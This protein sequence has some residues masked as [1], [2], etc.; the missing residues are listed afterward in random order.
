MDTRKAREI[1]VAFDDD[2]KAY[3]FKEYSDGLY[4]YDTTSDDN[5]VTSTSND[6]LNQYS[7]LQT[8]QS[9]QSFFSHKDLAMADD[10]RLLQQRLGFPGTSTMISYIRNN[11][12]CNTNVT[13]DDVCRGETVYGP[14]PQLLKGKCVDNGQ[15]YLP[16]PN[17]VEVHPL[18][19]NQCL[20]LSLF[21]DHFYVNGLRFHLTHTEKLGFFTTTF[22]ERAGGAVTIQAFESVLALHTRRG[23]KI[24]S[25]HGDNE[26]NSKKLHQALPDLFFHSCAAE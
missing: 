6:P 19:L 4:F 2:R 18:I 17:P 22:C 12:I 1:F 25:I 10:A 23:F 21:V 9:N 5:D 15:L 16:P 13:I 26:F 3:T 7:F 8:V 24:T 11:L 20:N 14:L